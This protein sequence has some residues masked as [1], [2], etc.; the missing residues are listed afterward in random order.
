MTFINVNGGNSIL[1][2]V[3]LIFWYHIVCPCDASNF[4]NIWRVKFCEMESFKD[5]WILLNPTT[6]WNFTYFESFSWQ[7]YIQGLLVEFNVNYGMVGADAKTTLAYFN[8]LSSIGPIMQLSVL[9]CEYRK[10]YGTKIKYMWEGQ[11]F[12]PATYFIGRYIPSFKYIFSNS[13]EPSV[14]RKDLRALTLA[15][16]TSQN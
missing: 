16:P 4:P 6:S 9:L 15:R 12:N 10:V 13:G 5:L 11:F 7:S 14:N 8:G 1:T 2:I 3:L